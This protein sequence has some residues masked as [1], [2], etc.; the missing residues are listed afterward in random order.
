MKRKQRRKKKKNVKSNDFRKKEEETL[1]QCGQIVLFSSYDFLFSFYEAVLVMI[2]RI[3]N[4]ISLQQRQIII[5][6]FKKS[7]SI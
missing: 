1:S 5:G 4:E 3:F 2:K 6:E 7:K